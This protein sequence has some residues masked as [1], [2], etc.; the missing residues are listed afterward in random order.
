METNTLDTSS[1]TFRFQGQRLMLTYRSHIDKEAL[2]AFIKTASG[3]KNLAFARCAHETGDENHPYE[4]THVVVDFGKPW[5]C[6]NC[7]RLDYSTGEGVIHPNWHPIKTATHF[8]NAKRYLC[9]EDA[10]NLDLSDNAD[11][12]CISKI[13]AQPTLGD[14]LL[15]CAASPAQVPGIIAAYAARPGPQVTVDIPTRPWQVEILDL[16]AG[17]PD[18]RDIHWI[19]DPVGATGKTWLARYLLVNKLAYV[20]KQCGGSYHFATVMANAIASGWDQR[21]MVFDLPR[22]TEE[23]SIYA[24]IEEVKDGM[25]T[26]LKYQGGTLVFNQPHVLIFANY[27][28][29]LEAMSLDRWKIHTIFRGDLTLE[30]PIGAA[31]R[32]LMEEIPPSEDNLA[33]LTDQELDDLIGD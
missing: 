15:T 4:H 24:P 28:P 5:Q 8:R 32:H 27:M 23:H 7:R 11:S 1:K 25:V 22:S 29:K 30:P 20:V 21:V 3:I 16:I 14:A 13:W 12:G 19:Y 2:I 6:K 33:L 10:D 9:K 26:A 31:P 17:P 18:K